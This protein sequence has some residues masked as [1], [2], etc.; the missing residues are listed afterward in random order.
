MKSIQTIELIVRGLA[1]LKEETPWAEFKTNNADPDAAGE[2][3]SALSNMAL[4][5][6]KPYG[7]LIWGIDD[8][9]HSFVGT[10]LSFATW[11]KGHEDILAYWRNLLI[12][13]LSLQDYELRIDGAH[14]LV[15][16]IPAASHYATTFKKQAYCRIGSYTKNLKEYPALEKELWEKLMAT[17]PEERIVLSGIALQELPSLFGIES[18]FKCLGLPFP[19]SLEEVAS[20]FIRE[21][22]LL[23]DE[24]G[25]YGITE[26][27]ALLFGKD[28]S[29]FDGL[30]SKEIRL[31]RY[32]GD[33][34][35]ETMGKKTFSEGYALSFEQAYSTLLSLIQGADVFVN[36][37]RKDHY[38]IP[39]L[40]IRE[41]LGN[42]LIHQDLL[43]FGGPLI[44]IFPSRI[45]F[46]NPGVLAVPAD[47]LIDSSP[48][49]IN[50][51]L[52]S[53]LRRINIGDTAGSGF[54]KIVGSLEKEH[55]PP[56]RVRETPSGVNVTLFG[57]VP[58]DELSGEQKLQVVYDHVVLRYL[59]GSLANNG[60]LRER[61]G[62]DESGKYRVSR[63]LASAIE[64]GK[65]KKSEGLDK[66]ETAYLPYWA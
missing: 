53:F 56:V 16:E 11:K 65:I 3:I 62:L 28:L 5:S 37:I 42:L 10:S 44:E 24:S 18:Y 7:Y 63:L 49:P 57:S 1:S 60:S 45:E 61:F 34:R 30:E 9:T 59:S 26:L 23:A 32:A 43:G 6:G 21:E 66:K 25:K 50:E 4:L 31:V 33:D 38:R 15:L 51:H 12:P 46:S 19:S 54:D 55:L 20:R 35:L 40:A 41:C 36:G 22:F 14:V 39:P 17:S 29:S 58:F 27:G 8:E 2:R 64:K 47:R 52:A 48:K 13:S